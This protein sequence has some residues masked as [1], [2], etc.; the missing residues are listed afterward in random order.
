MTFGP[1]I[2]LD[3]PFFFRH[4]FKGYSY[5]TNTD[6]SI[7]ADTGELDSSKIQEELSWGGY[8]R[9]CTRF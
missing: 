2:H 3:G 9:E 8:K 6:L 4:C 1:I 5:R 7:R